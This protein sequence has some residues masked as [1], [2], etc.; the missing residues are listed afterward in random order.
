ME[1]PLVLPEV[2]IQPSLTAK[3]LGVVLDKQ[4]TGLYHAQRLHEGAMVTI[5]GFQAISGSTRGITLQ[6]DVQLYKAV[7]RPKAHIRKHGVI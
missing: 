4:L 6:Q 7:L 5:D 3:L 1:A 2:T